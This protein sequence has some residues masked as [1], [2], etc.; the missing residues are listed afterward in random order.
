MELEDSNFGAV[1][2]HGGSYGVQ[3]REFNNNGS[4]TI[5]ITGSNHTEDE[6]KSKIL[7]F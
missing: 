3:A 7:R 2:N 4:M 1:H 6:K 5:N